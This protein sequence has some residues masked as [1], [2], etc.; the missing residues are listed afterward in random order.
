MSCQSKDSL[1]GKFES[2]DEGASTDDKGCVMTSEAAY[3]ST[4]QSSSLK[5]ASDR[6]KDYPAYTVYVRVH[7]MSV[8]C[9][10]LAQ[11]VFD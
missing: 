4:W 3:G 11:L 10:V 7:T 1:G 6:C 8:T 2:V 5:G 9:A